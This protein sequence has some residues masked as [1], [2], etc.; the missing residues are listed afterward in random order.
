MAGSSVCLFVCLLI[1]S[2]M[3]RFANGWV[4]SL[5]VYF[6]QAGQPCG[7]SPDPVLLMAGSSVRNNRKH[8]QPG[9]E[10]WTESQ[11]EIEEINPGKHWRG[12]GARLATQETPSPAHDSSWKTR[13]NQN[14]TEAISFKYTFGW[15]YGFKIDFLCIQ[16][17]DNHTLFSNNSNITVIRIRTAFCAT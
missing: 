6:L 11:T 10:T 12:A 17:Y 9:K 14:Y 1:S 3:G 7:V 4:L 8:P 5:F 13:N 16:I 15:N 2:R